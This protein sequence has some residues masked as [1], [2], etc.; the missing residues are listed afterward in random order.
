MDLR[1]SLILG[2]NKALSDENLYEFVFKDNEINPLAWAS[3]TAKTQAIANAKS[4][5]IISQQMLV[6]SLPM[7]NGDYGTLVNGDKAKNMVGLNEQ[8]GFKKE[9]WDGFMWPFGKSQPE[10]ACL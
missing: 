2:L 8:Y 10:C 4:S 5:V 9:L 7:E 3:R 1:G 6:A